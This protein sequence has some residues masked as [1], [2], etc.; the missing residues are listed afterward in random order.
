MTIEEPTIAEISL[1]SYHLEIHLPTIRTELTSFVCFACTL[2][3]LNYDCLTTL[4]SRVNINLYR[5]WQGTDIVAKGDTDRLYFD[6]C[7][8]SSPK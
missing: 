5:G 8:S 1:I 4:S 2:K 3:A 6:T 7:Q